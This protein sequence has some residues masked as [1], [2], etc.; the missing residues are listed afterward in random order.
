MIEIEGIDPLYQIITLILALLVAI[1]GH[2]IMHGYVAY[3]YG[4]FTAKNAG[5][6][7]INPLVHIDPIGSILVP[8]LLYISGAP[9]LFGWAKPVPVDSYVVLK[10]GGYN[11]GIAVSLA[12]IAYNFALAILSVL[13]LGIVNTEEFFGA[14]VALFLL[15]LTLYNVV[16]GVFNLWPIPPLDGSRALAYGCLKYRFMSLPR[17]FGQL[18]PYGMIIL[19]A[20]LATP[21]SQWFFYPVRLIL[22]FLL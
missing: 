12:G 14:I 19:V 22:G 9:F 18:E 8:G 20:I 7:S 10:N 5:R 2:E 21:L 4:D 3:R 1:I 15:Q 11:A 17:L 13:L 6:L 16:L